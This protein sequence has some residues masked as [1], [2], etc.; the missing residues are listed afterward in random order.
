MA[1]SKIS[2][3]P[4][5]T[6]PLAGT[7][8]VVVVQGGV[9]KRVA[10]DNLSEFYRAVLASDATSTSTTPAAVTGLDMVLPVGTYNVK[11]WMVLRAAATT[12]GMGIH[13]KA[14]GGTVTTIA[15]TWYSLTTGTTATTGVM[16]QASVA[17][18]FQT[19]EGRAQRVNDTSGG[20]FGGVDTANADQ[21]AVLEGL[22]VVTAQTT[23]QHMMATEVAGSQVLMKAGSNTRIVK[24]A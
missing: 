20:P 17:A 11:T 8:E 22:V 2:A 21:F 23:L 5:A 16:D 15:A 19:L 14:N 6:V 13:L 1:D 4:A 10:V 7:E 9:S 18:T 24:V 12:T 3:L